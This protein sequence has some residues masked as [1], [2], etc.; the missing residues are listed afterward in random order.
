MAA[1]DVGRLLIQLQGAVERLRFDDDT[2]RQAFLRYYG[3]H[4][5]ERMRQCLLTFRAGRADPPPG[6][7]G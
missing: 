4:L 3:E 5:D 6:A 1:D 2:E 7:Q